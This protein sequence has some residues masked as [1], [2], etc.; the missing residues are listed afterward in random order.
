MKR[1]L[2]LCTGNSCRSQ[3]AEGYLRHF[4][5]NKA[6][7]YSAGVETHGVNPRAIATMQEDG[8]DISGHTSNNMEEYRDID[9]DYVITVCDNAKERCPYFP[10]KALKFH[11]N[12]PDPAKATGSEEVIMEQFRL[13]RKQIKQY[14]SDFIQQHIS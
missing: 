12:F 6:E 14:C 2:V 10:G 5:K 9:F 13:V 4:A 1:I 8:I 3:L 11:Y 7:I